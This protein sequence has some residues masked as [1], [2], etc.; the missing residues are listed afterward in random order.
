MAVQVQR[1][2]F[3]KIRQKL[4]KNARKLKVWW[5]MRLIGLLRKKIGLKDFDRL[6]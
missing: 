3:Q 2:S 4:P 6:S 1:H 5:W